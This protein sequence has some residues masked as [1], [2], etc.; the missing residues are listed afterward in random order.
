VCLQAPSEEASRTQALELKLQS[1]ESQIIGLTEKLSNAEQRAN[2]SQAEAYA[3]A[4]VSED[5]QGQLAHAQAAEAALTAQLQVMEG[6]LQDL[7]ENLSEAKREAEEATARHSE[8]LQGQLADAHA[9]EAALIEQLQAMESKLEELTRELSE[10]EQDAEAS[11]AD[12]RAN[13]KLSEDL[14]GQLAHAQATEAT[15]REQLQAV[16]GKMQK[17]T[18]QMSEAEQDAGAVKVKAQANAR[19]SEDLQGQLTQVEAAEADLIDQLNVVDGKLQEMTAKLAEA[20]RDAEAS[21]VEARAHASLSEDLKGQLAKA[22]AAEARATEQ[23]QTLEDDCQQLKTSMQEMDQ[24]IQAQQEEHQREL[25]LTHMKMLD[26]VENLCKPLQ[27]VS[28]TSK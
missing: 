8:D 1:S 13:A 6:K 19:L 23:L 17:L 10:A 5:L 15:A 9:A 27:E 20:E 26:M 28:S 14:Q 3:N 21:K 18:Q 11:K 12:A 16:E 7:N 24:A 4:T 2:A 25:H 22:H